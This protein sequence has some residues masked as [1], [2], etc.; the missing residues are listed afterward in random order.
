MFRK[1]IQPIELYAIVDHFRLRMPSISTTIQNMLRLS[2]DARRCQWID[3]DPR[4][5]EGRQCPARAV[6]PRAYCR[7]HAAQAYRS[8]P[9]IEI[10]LAPHYF[11]PAP[12]PVAAL[13]DPFG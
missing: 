5:P 9:A 6:P 7:E 1:T 10:E 11:A 8:P 12:R 2:H 13:P 4:T 3:G